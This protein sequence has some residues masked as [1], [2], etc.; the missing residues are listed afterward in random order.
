MA[1]H[2]LQ[3]L[4]RPRSLAIVGASATPG[5]VGQVMLR[6]AIEGGFRGKLYP[7]NPRY[8]SLEG[9]ACYPTLADLPE[10]PDHVALAVANRRVEAQLEAALDKGARAASIAAALT[11]AEDGEPPLAAR[12]AG[13]AREAKIPLCGGNS[14]G[15]YNFADRV[16]ICGFATRRD[17]RSGGIALISHSGSAMCALVDGEARIDFGLAV[18]TGQELI[19]TAADYL[20]FALEMPG[21]RVVGLFLEGLRD[22]EGF[23]AALEK[24]RR[25]DI[26]VVALKLGRSEGAARMAYSH[27]GALVGDDGAFQ[28]LCDRYGVTRVATIDELAY[29]LMMFAQPHTVGPGGLASLHDSGGERALFI[30]LAADAAVPFAEL[31]PE[32]LAKLAARLDPGLPAVNPLDAWGDG[33]D[34]AA[35]YESC[36]TAMMQDPATALGALVCDRGAGGKVYPDY[37]EIARSAHAASGKACFIVSSHQGSGSSETAVAATRAGFPVIDG[38]ADFLKGVRHL[39]ERRDFRLRPEA[40]P[41]PAPPVGVVARWRP[42]LTAGAPLAEAEA[43]ALIADFG[44]P[45]NPSRSAEGW[46]AVEAAAAALGYPVVL[47]TAQPEILH[48]S[49][50]GGVKLDLRDA[51]ALRRA[52][53]EL[54]GRLGPRVTVAPMARQGGVEMLLGLYHD[55]QFGPVVVLGGGGLHAETLRDVVFALPPFDGAAARRLLDRL[56]MRPL[57]DGGWG[58]APADVGALAE[59]AA[60]FSVLAAALGPQLAEIDINPLLVGPQGCLALDARVIGRAAPATARASA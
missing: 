41:P 51:A 46:Q 19:T 31:A 2:P 30:D 12:I 34:F 50:H 4:L 27:S 13:L 40:A 57:L 49:D 17:H 29:G 25:Q 59:V 43:M 23:V 54:A 33:H 35:T 26:P 60:R 3:P 22:P 47:K 48:K 39:F 11:L 44:L 1:D 6:Q 42:R 16:R 20:D 52:Y 10:A 38:M 36:L 7:V 53:R 56:R 18:S 24:A 5:S 8:E 58:T 21:T 32:T 9:L 15:L 14:T 55:A 37:P 28:A 45:A